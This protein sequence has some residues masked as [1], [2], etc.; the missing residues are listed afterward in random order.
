MIGVLGADQKDDDAKKTYCEGEIDKTEDEIKE[1]KLKGSDLAKAAEDAKGQIATLGEEIVALEQGVKDLDAQVAEAT[2]QR[3]EENSEFKDVKAANA[4]AIELLGM[5]KKRLNKFYNP[6]LA[7]VQT[8]ETTEGG[9]PETPSGPYKKSEES[10]GVLGMI[11]ML[12]ADLEKETT[13]MEVEEENAQEEYEKAQKDS[14]SKRS[15]DLKSI[16]EKEGAKADA[17]A[18]LDKIAEET[19]ATLDSEMATAEILGAIHKE[20]DWLLSNYDV[21]KEARADEVEAL[22][23]AKAVLSGADYSFLQTKRTHAVIHHL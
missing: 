15:A 8:A 18:S 3:K 12:V 4:A 7:F 6:K 9:Q 17:E 13:E 1:L 22:N 2:E 14:S 21:R 16:E 19:K 20:C 11:D 5:A 23:K 10:A